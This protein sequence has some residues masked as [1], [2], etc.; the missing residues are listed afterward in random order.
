MRK[1]RAGTVYTFEPVGMDLWDSKSTATK[2]E[3]VRVVALPGCPKP[4]TM[5]HCHIISTTE[6]ITVRGERR[7]KFL[8]LVLTNSLT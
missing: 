6:F 3:R 2:G 8:G 7:G 4:N 1:V 5:G